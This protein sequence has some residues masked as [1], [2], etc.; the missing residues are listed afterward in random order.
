[1]SE[2]NSS[3]SAATNHHPNATKWIVVTVL[4]L[5]VIAAVVQWILHRYEAYVARQEM[6]QSFVTAQ[7][8]KIVVTDFFESQHR[9]PPNAREAGCVDAGGN[10][11]GAPEVAGGQVVVEI[12]DVYPD[13]NGRHAILQAVDESGR[14]TMEQ[15][16]Y[17]RGGAVRTYRIRWGSTGRVDQS[18]PPPVGWSR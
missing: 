11:A 10:G 9:F 15:D 5:I 14:L 7:A 8:C 18:T 4:G 16:G 6:S 13:V 12:K 2:S 3:G 1:M 17:R